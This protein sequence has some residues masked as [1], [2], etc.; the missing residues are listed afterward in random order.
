MKCIYM[1]QKNLYVTQVSDVAHGLFCIKLQ[2][3][4]IHKYL[5]LQNID[6]CSTGYIE[7]YSASA[8]IGNGI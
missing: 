2:V 5:Q 1:Y 3:G 7:V 4:T 8:G 6:K